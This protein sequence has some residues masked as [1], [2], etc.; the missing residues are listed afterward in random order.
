MHDSS[1]AMQRWFRDYALNRY[2]PMPEA[3]QWMT[4]DEETRVNRGRTITTYVG[5]IGADHEP[6][7]RKVRFETG[8]PPP[9]TFMQPARQK[10]T[11]PVQP[12]GYDRR[13]EEKLRARDRLMMEMLW[14]MTKPKQRFIA[15]VLPPVTV[16]P[17]YRRNV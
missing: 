13:M 15:E 5:T 4:I 11:P 17:T 6:G 1:S 2:E 9:P 7:R 14:K 10:W 8:A 16:Q 12:T 3:W